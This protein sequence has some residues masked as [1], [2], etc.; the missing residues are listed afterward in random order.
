M[1]GSDSQGIFHFIHLY[2]I[3]RAQ[4]NYLYLH[5]TVPSEQKSFEVL[6]ATSQKIILRT[7]YKHPF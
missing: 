2:P 6:D 7:Y 4:K 1:F 3:L 5:G